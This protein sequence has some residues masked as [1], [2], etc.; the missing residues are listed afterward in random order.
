MLARPPK[1]KIDLLLSNP[2]DEGVIAAIMNECGSEK[3][4]FFSRLNHF[5]Q[6]LKN[7]TFAD[8]FST[9]ISNPSMFSPETPS[10]H[11]IT[12]GEALR[13]QF[14]N[15]VSDSIQHQMEELQGK[16]QSAV[17]RMQIL[18]RNVLDLTVAREQLVDQLNKKKEAFEVHMSFEDVE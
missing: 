8:L 3:R 15:S 12:Q 6:N 14:D 13:K 18:E 2:S 7:V 10:T 16:A 9:G 4:S 5:Y 1:S 17:E 11:L